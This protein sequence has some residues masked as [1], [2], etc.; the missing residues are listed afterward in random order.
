MIGDESIRPFAD[1]RHARNVLVCPQGRGVAGVR[2][3]PIHRFGGLGDAAIN[4]NQL[5]G[6][7]ELF[8]RNLRKS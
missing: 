1:R 8:R 4:V 2:T 7:R 3:E 6:A 5:D